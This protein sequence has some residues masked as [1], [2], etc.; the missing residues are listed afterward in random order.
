MSPATIDNGSESNGQKFVLQ[1]PATIQATD[2]VQFQLVYYNSSGARVVLPT[3]QW[4]TSDTTQSY[5]VLSYNNGDF[6]ASTAKTP[7][8]LTI[9]VIYQDKTYSAN[10]QVLPRQVRERGV[11][12]SDTTHMP[13]SGVEVDFYGFSDI[14]NDT[15]YA[16][17]A[18]VD[19]E[20]NPYTEYA[21]PTQPNITNLVF[22]GKTTTQSDGTFRASV[23]AGTYGFTLL[24]SSVPVG[25]QRIFRY[26]GNLY[27]TGDPTPFG[28]AP[29]PTPVPIVTPPS[30]MLPNPLPD[31][32]T[33]SIQAQLPVLSNYLQNGEYLLATYSNTNPATNGTVELIPSSETVPMPTN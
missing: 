27:N 23:P 2:Q 30:T 32:L 1:D 28:L 8:P 14:T 19:T 17:Q 20:G 10:Y 3:D 7:A 31:P 13:L 18:A 16:V 26:R 22:L 5:G 15:P 9:S 4:S 25:Y 6:A 11:L 29:I 21:F 12:Q 24:S 33:A